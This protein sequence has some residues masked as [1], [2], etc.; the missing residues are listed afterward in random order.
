MEILKNNPNKEFTSVKLSILTG[1]SIRRISYN[2]NQ[3]CSMNIGFS[4][5]YKTNGNFVYSLGYYYD[6]KLTPTY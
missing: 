5:S 6:E 3:V 2:M 4:E 1:F